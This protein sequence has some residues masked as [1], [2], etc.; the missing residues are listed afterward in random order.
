MEYKLDAGQ[1]WLRD[2]DTNELVGIKDS[3]DG[4]E[5]FLLFVETNAITGRNIFSGANEELGNYSNGPDFPIAFPTAAAGAAGN[6]NGYYAWAVTFVTPQGETECTAATPTPLQLTN[7]QANISNIPVSSDDEVTARKL[8][9]TVN[10]TAGNDPALMRQYCLVATINDNTTTTYTDNLS[11]ASITGNA[12][13]PAISTAV[14][15]FQRGTDF[16]GGLIGTSLALGKNALALKS[17]YAN[18]AIGPWA[19]TVNTKGLRCVAVGTYALTSN[20][21]GN[22][23]TAI[24]VHSLNSNVAACDQTAIGYGALMNQTADLSASANTA[25]GSYALYNANAGGNVA[26]GMQCLMNST[27]GANNSGVGYKALFALTSGQDNSALG[28]QAC[29]AMQGGNFNTAIG[30]FAHS[31]ASSGNFN[32]SLGFSSLTSMSNG[33]G[34]IAIG[35]YAGKYETG[36]NA[37]YIDN[38]DRTNLATQKTNSLFYG[39]F[40]ADPKNQRLAINGLVKHQGYTVAT[41]PAAAGLTGYR[42]YVTDANATLTA[43]IGAV[44]AAGGANVVP[45]FCDGTNWRIG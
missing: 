15:Y 8:Y 43:G 44:V 1:Q 35:A 5:R 21:V 25:I 45:V 31:G 12:Q 27:S 13:V 26:I 6:L 38:Q 3:V 18:T 16:Y 9:R 34:C 32:T 17:G 41:L 24:G 39:V 14:P 7:R 30:M 2:V 22:R 28:Y 33:S 36:S 37:F 40:D 10:V 23:N 42:G 11:D 4:E 19:M 20:T 29:G